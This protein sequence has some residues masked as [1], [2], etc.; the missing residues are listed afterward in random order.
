[1]GIIGV[2]RDI[3]ERKKIMVQL[4]ESE[5]KFRALAEGCPF[6]IM[7]YQDDYWVYAN[8]AAEYISGYSKEE[9]YQLQ[10][11]MIVHPD[12]QPLVRH[13]GEQRQAGNQAPPAYDFKIIN[14]AGE[15]VWVSLAGAGVMYAGKPAGFITVIDINDRKKTEADLRESEKK[16]RTILDSIPENLRFLTTCFAAFPAIPGKRSPGCITGNIWMT[17]TQRRF[18]RYLM[19]FLR[20]GSLPGPVISD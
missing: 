16:Y 9:L 20:P 3:T 5:A 13:R 2:N 12:Y 6:A 1:V 10:F 4:Q 18:Y 7:I 11:W 19:R 17:K 14:K 8:P 15:E